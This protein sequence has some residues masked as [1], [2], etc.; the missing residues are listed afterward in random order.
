MKVIFLDIDGVLATAYEFLM[1]KQKFQKK[2][3]VAE[4]LNIPYPFNDGCV[5]VFNE[6]LLK[7]NAEIVLSSDWRKFWTLEELDLIFRFNGVIKSPMAVTDIDP[8][9]MSWLEKNRAGEIGKYLVNNRDI[10][11]WVAID[12]LNMSQF[13]AQT[14]DDDKMFVTEGIEGIKKSTLKDKII[15]K[16]NEQK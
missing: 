4:H 1:N 2:N 15:S 3:Y 6:I 16:L 5:K 10:E 11:Q 14:N 13:M 8:V 9:S 7:T 12:D